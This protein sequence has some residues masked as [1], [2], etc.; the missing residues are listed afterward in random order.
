[1]HVFDEHGEALHRYIRRRVGNAQRAQDLAQEAYLRLLRFEGFEL[2]SAPQAYL[3]RIASNLINEWVTRE[4][5]DA[6]TFNS[7]LSERAS[8]RTSDIEVTDPAEYFDR[9]Q[10]IDGALAQ[11]PQLYAAILVMKKR[12]GFSMEEIA[13][14]LDLSVHTVKK[15]LTRALTRCREWMGKTS[16]TLTLVAALI[17]GCS[18]EPETKGSLHK[19]ECELNQPR[20]FIAYKAHCLSRGSL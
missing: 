15:Y 6:V 18:R 16:I 11:L 13:S 10:Q 17:A 1:M 4:R 3:F 5:R 7:W 8:Q 9:Q 14:E 2:I 19:P 20:I 12:D